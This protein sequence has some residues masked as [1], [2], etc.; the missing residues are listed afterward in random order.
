MLQCQP[1]VVRAVMEAKAALESMG[2][3]VNLLFIYKILKKICVGNTNF[4][5]LESIEFFPQRK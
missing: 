3:Q 1:P 5:M 4:K 2:H